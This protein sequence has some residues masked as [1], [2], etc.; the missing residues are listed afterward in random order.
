[1]GDGKV[2]EIWV[3]GP[4]VAGGYWKR[5][6]LSR[7]VFQ[8]R[9]QDGRGPFLRTGDLGFLLEGE[10]FVTGRLKDLIIIRG[11]N[12]YPQDI[13]QTVQAA[14]PDV[15]PG[16]GCGGRRRVKTGSEQLVIVQEVVRRRDLDF[17]KITEAIRKTSCPCP[18]PVRRGCGIDQGKQH[19]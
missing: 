13:E 3:S 14:H 6:D 18:R 7:D 4:S 10:L 1:M 12:H 8:A 17:S 5:D 16:A 9:L 15:V 2:G 19:S 11:V